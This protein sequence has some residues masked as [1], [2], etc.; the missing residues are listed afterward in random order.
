MNPSRLLAVFAFLAFSVAST[1]YAGPWT[2][3]A[4]SAYVKAGQG[5][6]LAE[7]FI[8]SNG[9][10]QSGTE[11]VGRTTSV[12]AE[13]G[14]LERL[15][16]GVY[17]PYAIATNTTDDGATF[18]RGS[19]GDANVA[20]QYAPL[21]GFL[22]AFRLDTKIPLYDLGSYEGPSADLLPAQGDGQF[23]FTL[24][25]AY[26]A[27]FDRFFATIDLGYQLRTESF[28]GDGPDVQSEFADTIR[29][30]ASV[31][32]TVVKPTF[33]LSLQA[34]VPVEEDDRTKGSVTPGLGIY[35]PIAKG[36]AAEA[37]GS[38]SVWARNSSQ[39]I[40]FSL[41]LSYQL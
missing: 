3:S 22:G 4:G 41:G 13:F 37:N 26:G 34:D 8:D 40:S 14:V 19:L 15:H 29:A 30:V 7:G 1:A 32:V 39:G 27:T 12:Y 10:F 5:Y 25:A 16:V 9:V 2:K 20:I 17:L 28:V 11:Y 31:G 6:Y 38:Y 21:S 18:T 33:S 35:M 23:D 24:W 36:F